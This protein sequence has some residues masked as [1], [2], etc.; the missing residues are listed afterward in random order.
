MLWRP[1][2]NGYLA[3]DRESRAAVLDAAGA[4]ATMMV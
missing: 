2:R 4:A 3:D 1:V